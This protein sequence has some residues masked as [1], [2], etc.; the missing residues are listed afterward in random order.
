MNI[1]DVG[2]L[3]SD[4]D[5]G[6][7][8]LEKGA[9]RENKSVWEIAEFYTN[10]FIKDIDRLNI[11]KPDHLPKATDHIPEQ[12]AL[13]QKLQQKEYTYDTANALYFDVSKFPGYGK[14]SGQELTAKKTSRS[15]VVKDDNKKNPADFALWFKLVG[16]FKNHIMH[17]P[18][19]WG[20]GFPGWH[21]ECSAMSTKYLG[22]PFDIHTGGIDH[23][24]VH[25][26]NEIAQ[27]EAAFGLPLA[28]YWMHGEFLLIDEGRMGKSEGN[29]ITLN[30]LINKG[31]NPLAYRY[32]LLSAH[33]R[34]KLN[35]TY[36][37]L[38]GAQNAL[39]NLYSE[40][41][42]IPKPALT[43]LPKYEKAFMEKI[44][45]DLNLPEALA[46]MWDMIRSEQNRTKIL[47]SLIKFDKVL[48]L[49]LKQIHKQ[50]S[51]IPKDILLLA[52]QRETARHKKDFKEADRLRELM[53]KSGYLIE[54]GP[55]AQKIK[56]RF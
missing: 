7:D 6:Q 53:E 17:W 28:N 46:V 47:K 51:K 36:E 54:D 29:F 49:N 3:T 31:F 21:I 43:G 16:K 23:K 15:E 13:I 5:E 9:A 14:L 40:V 27:S 52:K 32:L 48:G 37:S 10:Q 34:T 4:A 24:P 33:Y 35:F 18:S 12:I 25:H 8:K 20:E 45:N 1:T 55:D 44:S 19:P 42:S 41:A 11:I 39:N 22:Q 30:D 50:Y 56:K 26:S 2:H 38:T